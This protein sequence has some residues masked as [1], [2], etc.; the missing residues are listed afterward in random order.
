MAI[1]TTMWLAAATV[2]QGRVMAMTLPDCLFTPGASNTC[3][4]VKY[5]Q[6]N[7]AYFD[8]YQNESGSPDNPVDLIFMHNSSLVVI[9]GI[10]PNHG[11][12]YCADCSPGTLTTWESGYGTRAE[13]DT[14][15]KTS[16]SSC[17]GWDKHLR[18]YGNYG[19][20]PGAGSLYDLNWGWFNIAA[21]HIDVNDWF[22]G[23]KTHSCPD[24][25]KQFGWQEE[26]EKRIYNDVIGDAA[27]DAASSHPSWVSVHNYLHSG[28]TNNVY[29][30][31]TYSYGACGG[32][33]NPA[34]YDFTHYGYWAEKS[35]QGHCEE[36]DGL[37][38]WIYV[39]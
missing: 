16:I 23:V 29:S 18:L 14:G 21:S 26:A 9:Q 37:A 39:K 8:N 6:N 38:A 34:P 28:D 36:S 4:Q 17:T 25:N 22:D 24:A 35:S 11:Y 30:G 15:Y 20:S 10:L 31:S 33:F 2:P 13:S 27:F 32:R 7:Q 19:G 3:P 1:I 12:N 5:S